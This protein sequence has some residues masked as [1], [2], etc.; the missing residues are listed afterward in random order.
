MPQT[1]VKTKYIFVI[2]NHNI[3]LTKSQSAVITTMNWQFKTRLIT[4][5][6]PHTTAQLSQALATPE[7]SALWVRV[8]L[9]DRAN[10]S[11]QKPLSTPCPGDCSCFTSTEDWNR[12]AGHE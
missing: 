2:I 12:G 5:P 11:V 4:L 8:K 10:D 1:G 6:T 9:S 7:P 3:T